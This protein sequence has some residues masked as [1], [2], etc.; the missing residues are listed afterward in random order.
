[1]AKYIYIGVKCSTKGCNNNARINGMCVNCRNKVKVWR[2]KDESN[3]SKS[4]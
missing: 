2:K 3:Q 4:D 1:M